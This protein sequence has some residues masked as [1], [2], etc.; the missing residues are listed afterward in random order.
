MYNMVGY[1]IMNSILDGMVVPSWLE[2]WF[3]PRWNC[4][5]ILDGTVVPSGMELWFHPRWNCG[6]IRDGI[7]PK[8]AKSLQESQ[9]GTR[10]PSTFHRRPV[11]PPY[12]MSPYGMPPPG[13]PPWSPQWRRR[14]K[15]GE[16]E[17][18]VSIYKF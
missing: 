2:L 11:I 13:T 1:Y 17:I 3:H 10:G 9:D 14:E 7:P 5:S 6:S 4:G 8:Y 15:E 18:P 16:G 12:G